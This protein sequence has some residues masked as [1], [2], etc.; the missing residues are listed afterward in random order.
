[1]S[2]MQIMLRKIRSIRWKCPSGVRLLRGI[3]LVISGQS[4][5][6]EVMKVFRGKGT[7]EE[8]CL[9]RAIRWADRITLLSETDKVY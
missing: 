1:M 2:S 4:R 7:F 3:C 8:V 9:H 5:S 6:W